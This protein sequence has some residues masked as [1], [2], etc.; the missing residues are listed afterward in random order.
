MAERTGSLERLKVRQAALE[1]AITSLPNHALTADSR[2]RLLKLVRAEGRFV[3]RLASCRLAPS[4]SR[5][6]RYRSLLHWLAV[7]SIMLS[8]NALRTALSLCYLQE[9]EWCCIR[10]PAQ[11][12]HT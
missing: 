3:E 10:H 6:S 12:S 9:A 1:N 11:I 7:P 2:A 5:F 4:S 8:S